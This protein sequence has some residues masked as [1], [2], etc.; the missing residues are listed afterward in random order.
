MI[1]KHGHPDKLKAHLFLAAS[2]RSAV[3]TPPTGWRW[4]Y[5]WLIVLI[6]AQGGRYYRSV[7]PEVTY[8]GAAR[9]RDVELASS[10]RYTQAWLIQKQYDPWAYRKRR[11]RPEPDADLRPEA[12]A[13]AEP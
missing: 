12:E 1:K 2:K 9:M 7:G 13:E 3:E 5:G 4:T 8:E 11:R 10:D 6:D